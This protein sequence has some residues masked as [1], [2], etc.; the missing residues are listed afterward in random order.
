MSLDRSDG[1]TNGNI[2]RDLSGTNVVSFADPA[3]V[4]GAFTFIDEATG[5]ELALKTVMS[6]EN[7][8]SGYDRL[9]YDVPSDWPR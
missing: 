7:F 1:A 9:R 4:G 3:L 5:D 8:E 6:E 2:E